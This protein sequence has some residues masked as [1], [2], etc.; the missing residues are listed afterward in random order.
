MSPHALLI[1]LDVLAAVALTILGISRSRIG[2]ALSWI[3]VAAMVFGFCSLIA[4]SFSHEPQPS[5]VRFL[6][7]GSGLFSAIA[8]FLGFI[9]VFRKQR[10]TTVA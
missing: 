1:V 4:G 5:I 7:S 9:Y 8:L 10:E 6:D 2:V 3:V